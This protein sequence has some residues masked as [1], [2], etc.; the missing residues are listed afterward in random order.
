MVMKRTKFTRRDNGPEFSGLLGRLIPNEGS[1]KER[2]LTALA[3]TTLL[4]RAQYA[5][6]LGLSYGGDRDIYAALGYPRILTFE[7]YLARYQRQDIATRVIEAAA[8]ATWRRVPMVTDDEAKNTQTVFEKEWEKLT[9]DK[10]LWQYL[11]RLD[12][13]SGIG[14]YGVLFLGFDDVRKVDDLTKPVS[15]KAKLLYVRPFNEGNAD[16]ATWEESLASPRYGLPLAYKLKTSTTGATAGQINAVNVHYTRTIHVA[17]DLTEDDVYGTPRIKNVYNRLQ[18]LELIAGGSSEMFWR[19][20]FP[21]MAFEM[22]PEADVSSTV[23]T[24]MTEDIEDFVHQLKRYVR[25]QGVK[26]NNLALQVADPRGHVDVIIGMIAAAKGF[27][28]RILVGSEKGE[29]SSAQD[30]RQWN[31]QIDGRRKDFAE[32][33]IVRAVVDRLIETGTLPKPREEMYN[34]VWPDDIPDE[35][36]GAEIAKLRMEAADKYIN[37]GISQILPPEIFLSRLLGFDRAEVEEWLER[38]DREEEQFLSVE[39]KRIEH[40]NQIREEEATKE[41]KENAENSNNGDE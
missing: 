14:Q 10:R 30:E 34:V 18:D 27:P 7:H 22:D 2:F 38:I 37:M 5:S 3:A 26:A 21:G 13:I 40:E 15:N 41:E 20:A 12:K 31:R 23:I 16:I 36:N 28:K 1:P 29:L 35:R 4:S 25:L 9:K 39:D 32:N 6:K 24:Q 8:S 33:Q 17:E 11:R 19:G